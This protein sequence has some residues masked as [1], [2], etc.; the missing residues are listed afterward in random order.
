M[1][2]S[3]LASE[4]LDLCDDFATIL[5]GNSLQ[6]FNSGRLDKQPIACHAASDL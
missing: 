5:G 2:I 3:W 1:P 6:L 4:S